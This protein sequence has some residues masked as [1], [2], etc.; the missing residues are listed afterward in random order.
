MA[1]GS[2]ALVMTAVF[3]GAMAQRIAGLGF[4]LLVAP[5]LV[6]L[7]GAHEGVIMVNVCGLA[8]SALVLT[9]VWADVDWRL[10]LGL[11]VPAM[12]ASL[13]ASWLA[14]SLPPAPVSVVVGMVVL[15]GLV[16][17][18]ALQRTSIVLRDVGT[19]TLAG[20]L[21]G[22]S[23]AIAG[24]AGP[25]F[26]AYGLVARVPQRHFVATL[27]PLF[28]ATSIVT[29]ATKAA[30]SPEAAPD[31]GL[32]LW[33]LVLALIVGGVVVGDRLQRY[34]RDDQA[35]AVVIGLAF[36]GAAATVVDGLRSL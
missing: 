9:R 10:F 17:S 36:L 22:A 27:Q 13:P 18:W 7:L 20:A 19:R 11:G 23:N 32:P 30:T 33:V 12:S 8:S 29:L 31:I 1:L 2:V 6:L 14:L 21:G 5:F 16:V 35:R 24:A 28:L 26:T 3:V 15:A 4:A 25:A 34:I